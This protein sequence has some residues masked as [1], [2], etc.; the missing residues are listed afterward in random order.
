MNEKSTKPT[1]NLQLRYFKDASIVSDRTNDDGDL[2]V[3][4]WLLHHATLTMYSTQ[5]TTQV[6][7]ATTQT[8]T[9][10][11]SHHVLQLH[12]TDRPV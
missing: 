9:A 5:R 2:V 11:I 8:T 12:E 3:T 10:A 6:I 1:T 7:T 4:T